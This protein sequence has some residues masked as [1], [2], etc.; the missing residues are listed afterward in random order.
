MPKI[1][2]GP[3]AKQRTLRVLMALVDYG[4]DELVADEAG[5]E[6]LRSHLTLHWTTDRQLIVRTKLRYLEALV[7][8]AS[9]DLSK[10]QIKTALHHLENHLELLEDN[11]ASRRGS[12]VWHFT[13]TLWHHRR[14]RAALLS[15]FDQV[16]EQRRC[17]RAPNQ[18]S[19][20]PWQTHCQQ[21]LTNQIG[22]TH[23]LLTLS[24]PS[25]TDLASMHMPLAMVERTAEKN[26]QQASDA[27]TITTPNLLNHIQHNNIQALAIVGE[28]GA[29]KSTLLQQL[30]QQ[31]LQ[32]TSDLPILV[33]LA[34]L[35]DMTLEDYV[36][37]DWLRLALGQR[38]VE[39]KQQNDLAD[40]IEQGRGWLLLDALDEMNQGGSL[41]ITHL[42]QRLQGWLSNGRIIVT[43]R[44]N[45]WD[46][47]KNTLGHW[48][49]YHL[50]GYEDYRQ[51][52]QPFIRRWFASRPEQGKKLCRQLS[53]PE[54]KRLR[55]NLRNPLRLALFCRLGN[56]GQLPTT[57]HQLYQQFVTALYDWQQD[58]LPTTL[59]E[60]HQINQVLSKLALATLN[61]STVQFDLSLVT[62]TL[63]TEDFP[64]FERAIQLGW[65]TPLVTPT[66]EKVYGFLHGTFRD[67]FAAQGVDWQH[68]TTPQNNQLPMVLPDWQAVILLW[69]GRSD[70]ASSKKNALIQALISFKDN[71]GHFFEHRAWLLAGRA[72][73]E[74]P[75]FPQAD[76][77]IQQLIEWRFNLTRSTSP[78]L[79]EAAK[80][81]LAESDLS[82]VTQVLTQLAQDPNQDFFNRWMAAY[83]LGR[84][85]DRQSRAAVETLETLLPT[86]RSDYLKMDMARHLGTLSPGHALAI[87]TLV[88]IINTNEQPMAKRKASRRLAKI[89]PD[90]PLPITTLELLLSE[91]P[92]NKTILRA[93]ASLCPNHPTVLDQG[94]AL[95]APTKSHRQVK[96]H[97]PD[98]CKQ[99]NSLLTRLT[100]ATSDR[101]RLRLAQKLSQ[102][103]PGHPLAIEVLW[104]CLTSTQDK[105]QLRLACEALQVAAIDNQLPQLISKLRPRYE[106]AIVSKHKEQPLAYFKLLWTWADTLGYLPFAKAWQG[107]HNKL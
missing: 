80:A 57:Q 15:T 35:G 30:A 22:L 88:E 64:W 48:P 33:P 38:I 61:V 16:W 10:A 102:L 67:Y 27:T 59:L 42:A 39:P 100:T 21:A 2:Y 90:H 75:N 78:I 66:G 13:L 9:G 94:T 97:Q 44:L 17:D 74:Y 7:C 51:Q 87:N 55:N 93:L 29:G 12:D 103:Q 73:G 86:V 70:I 20:I 41:A 1:S 58:T 25:K 85:Y 89:A 63:S 79:I 32:Q 3:V 69:L 34:C 60:Q 24:A 62:Q 43:C 6:R 37:K 23:N 105:T 68:F 36:L 98:R 65:L 83:S 14:D 53:L 49:T 95:T 11:R 76:N 84:S 46:A 4:N 18:Q 104:H 31:I 50:L 101:N 77:I 8:L 72:L 5:L 92:Q 99:L 56:G 45:L 107:L 81:A 40:Q 26:T 106:Q 96:K 52:I 47:G 91:H 19:A 28:P 82:R 54:H 71:C